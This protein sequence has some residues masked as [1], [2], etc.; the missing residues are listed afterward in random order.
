MKIGVG[1]RAS[2]LGESFV[3]IANDASA[4]YWNP[5]GLVQFKEDQV[6]FSHNIWVVDI[7]HNFLGAVYHLDEANA[8]GLS[9]TSL[10][11]EDMPVTTEYQPFGTGEYFGFGD[12]AIALTYSRKMTDQFS[13]GGTVRYIE[14]TLDKL[15]NARFY[16]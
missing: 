1:A 12:L 15:K 3:A 16:D 10:S 5:A 14:E 8:F 7:S 2:G 13:F 11:M 9:F 6:L 4:I